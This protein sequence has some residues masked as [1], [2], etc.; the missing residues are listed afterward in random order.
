[1]PGLR[2][3]LASSV[4]SLILAV[5]A[6]PGAR[7]Q[8]TCDPDGLQDS[9]SIY[10]ICMPPPERFNGSLFVFA[11]GFQ[12]AGTPVE[13]PDDQLEFGG[14]SLPGL[15]NDL[16]FAF[17]TNSYSKTGLAIRQGSADILDL[18]DIY[19]QTY[20]PPDKVF[21]TG[22]SEGGIITALL[23]EQHPEVFAG[24]VAAC[25][26]IGNFR[27]QINYFADG[28]VLFEVFFPG[29]I[30]GDPLDPPEDLV[31]NWE[32]FYE[33]VVEP[34]VFAPANAATLMEYAAVAKLPFDPA[35]PIESLK[36]SVRD[37][38]RYAV[39]N[40]A[41][42]VETLGGFPFGNRLRWYTG[43]ADDVA[44]NGAVAR[45]SAD[46]A[47]L[48][49]M[50]AHYST[51]GR[52]EVP[53]ITLHTTLDQQVPFWHESLYAVKTLLSGA[54]LTRHLPIPIDRFEHCEFTAAEALIS[55]AALLLYTGDLGLLSGVGS[56]LPG[57]QVATFETLAQRHGLPY[58]LRGKRLKLIP[59]PGR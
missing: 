14:I 25:G 37:V 51:T 48:A 17:A 11:H 30:P 28:R 46:P 24:G 41:D 39:V 54:L 19:E 27:G 55:F 58:R 57:D 42:G 36:I 7:A 18:V 53:L 15:I 35:D 47:A 45:A 3:V 21:L 4:V 44:L 22:A 38:L 23:V 49:E 8:T 59:P 10:R 16:G 31:D 52:L 50:R 26:P 20:G 40:F 6:T 34:E 43:S 2:A 5:A 1:M 9:G 13:I 33:T 32:T 56:V 12:D 29:L